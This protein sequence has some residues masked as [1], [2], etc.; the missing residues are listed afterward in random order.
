MTI[1][2][3][4]HITNRLQAPE[5]HIQIKQ[6]STPKNHKAGRKEKEMCKPINVQYVDDDVITMSNPYLEQQEDGK[7][8]LTREECEK[9]N[10]GHTSRSA[11]SWEGQNI[12]TNQSMTMPTT[13]QPPSENH[14]R[15]RHCPICKKGFLYF[16]EIMAHRCSS[17]IDDK[18]NTR[19]SS[20]LD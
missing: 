4:R 7:R 10:T 12:Q 19:N 6:T 15:T 20:A 2:K 17:N 13:Q 11:S 5:N 8:A 14:S 9:P 3:Q 16:G 1:R 18:Q